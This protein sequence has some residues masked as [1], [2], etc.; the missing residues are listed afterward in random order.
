MNSSGTI[1][2][3]TMQLSLLSI[4]TLFEPA[5]IITVCLQTPLFTCQRW[6][7]PAPVSLSYY[8]LSWCNIK[9]SMAT[10]L[11]LYIVWGEKS[12][13]TNL[14][15]HR[16]MLKSLILFPPSV[17]PA[18]SPCPLA[19]RHDMVRGQAGHSHQSH[20]REWGVDGSS[21]AAVV[22]IIA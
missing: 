8:S 17:P 15:W 19:F 1:C 16:I 18:K 11:L 4:W 7:A 10:T 13:H 9:L 21:D 6:A 5:R 20:L 14:R 12:G 22:M 3:S 2:T